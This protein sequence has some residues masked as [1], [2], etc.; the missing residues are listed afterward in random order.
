MLPPWAHAAVTAAFFLVTAV[1]TIVGY[2]R[3]QIAAHAHERQPHDT[4]VISGEFA[5]G[6]VIQKLHE[7]IERQTVE[8]QVCSA[9]EVEAMARQTEAT[10]RLNDTVTRLGDFLRDHLTS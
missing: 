2:T 10:S 7:A 1:V 8:H 9:R 3:K 6:K 5:D 4:V